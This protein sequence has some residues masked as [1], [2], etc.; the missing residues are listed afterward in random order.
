MAIWEAV[1]DLKV[2]STYGGF[3]GMDVKDPQLK[4][5]I[6]QSMQTQVQRGG[7]KQAAILDE[8]I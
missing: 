1:R 4:G 6:L 2:E 8:K 7:W 3:A 5:R